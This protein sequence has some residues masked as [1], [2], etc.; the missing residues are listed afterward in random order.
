ME[1]GQWSSQAVS[2]GGMEAKG[3][4][5]DGV[6]GNGQRCAS[7]TACILLTVSRGSGQ[8]LI[9]RDSS[10]GRGIHCGACTQEG[11]RP[12]GWV[13]QKAGDVF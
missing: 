4:A 10:S 11:A 2:D 7:V 1:R 6:Q 9:F 8:G 12:E 5:G 13:I 3:E